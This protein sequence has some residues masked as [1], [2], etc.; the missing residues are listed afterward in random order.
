MNKNTS[1]THNGAVAHDPPASQGVNKQFTIRHVEINEI[2]DRGGV[3]PRESVQP[4]G[5]NLSAG[6]DASI[7]QDSSAE[8]IDQGGVSPQESIL[9]QG[10]DLYA[11]RRSYAGQDSSAAQGLPTEH[12]VKLI[13][14]GRLQRRQ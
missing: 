14:V 3:R 8:R 5:R 9:P 13:E 4:Q 2:I 6:Q 1:E 11:G 7:G 12:D 10:V